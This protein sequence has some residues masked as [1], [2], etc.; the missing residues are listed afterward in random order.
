[1]VTEIVD[2]D[3]GTNSSFKIM[4]MQGDVA[5]RFIEFHLTY[6]N[7]VF[8]LTGKTVSCR[9]LKDDKTVNTTNLVINDKL[10]GV[11]I[12]DVP[13]ELMENPYIARCE[14][15]IKQSNEVLST[16]PFT[17]EV[18]KSL[19]KS[20][21]V[22]SSDE[23]GALNEALWK[24]DGIKG[25]IAEIN[26]QLEQKVNKNEVAN[27]LT[28]KGNMLY[29]NLPTEGNGIGDYYYCSDGDGINGVGN[30]VWNGTE[31]YFGGS[32]D[33]GYS[34]LKN[35][36]DRLIKTDR[37]Y[38]IGFNNL[39]NNGWQTSS[40]DIWLYN[41]VIKKGDFIYSL[42]LKN[43][44][45][46]HSNGNII[47]YKK[48]NNKFIKIKEVNNI[49]SSLVNINYLC[50]YDTYVAIQGEYNTFI[51]TDISNSPSV[52]R[53]DND[54]NIVESPTD[55]SLCGKLIVYKEKNYK[56]DIGYGSDCKYESIQEA[57]D[58]ANVNDVL[59][60][61]NGTY[62]QGV[63]NKNKNITL[64]GESKNGVTIINYNNLYGDN[65]VWIGCGTYENINFIERK[66]TSM[67]SYSRINGKPETDLAY[68]IHI[69]H[70]NGE[71]NLTFNNCHIE[72]DLNRAVGI[73]LKRDMEISFNNCDIVGNSETVGA[74]FCHD[75]AYDWIGNNQILELN[76]N[77]I[78]TT[79]CEKVIE[80]ED[81][82]ISSNN[83]TIKA[84]RNLI[85][86][87]LE[88]S[89]KDNAITMTG[90]V[91]SGYLNS[92]SFN[93]SKASFSN[94]NNLINT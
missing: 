62:N 78:V 38:S 25:E 63:L 13:Y 42:E 9:Y 1:M 85:I 59:R 35:V 56:F 5:S 73:G 90:G 48:E 34:E 80:F 14:L 39:E 16:I 53:L 49:P 23:F 77:N 83:A 36:L 82:N 91:G 22:E 88:N 7:E 87:T 76:N 57:I 69:D 50:D 52:L 58:N 32:G 31:W 18:V 84:Y 81:M 89:S 70:M 20:C 67:S 29:T 43:G 10:N 71:Q 54:G 27:G 92:L 74:I 45:S 26:S 94:S 66:D 65:P 24:V 37:E 60:I 93:L 40:N 12:L 86:S 8:D 15:V 17:V 46:Y 3:L 6:N 21:I 11:C 64:V 75:C 2:L 41:H 33:G 44:A 30:Y 19:V 4:T 47:L 61:K 79:K 72:S 28:A 55:F 51:T 68:A